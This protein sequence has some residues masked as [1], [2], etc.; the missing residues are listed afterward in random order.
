[1]LQCLFRG[2]A[3]TTGFAHHQGD[4]EVPIGRLQRL[5][6]LERRHPEKALLRDL[7]V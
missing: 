6:G 4:S 7:Y 3:T 5:T 2:L 1:M